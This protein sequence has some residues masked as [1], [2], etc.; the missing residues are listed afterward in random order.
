MIDTSTL[1]DPINNR[2]KGVYAGEGYSQWDAIVRTPKGKLERKGRFE[3]PEAAAYAVAEYYHSVYG[4]NWPKIMRDW[5]RRKSW[6]VRRVKRYPYRADL[7]RG[8]S[9]AIWIADVKVCPISDTWYRITLK[10][11]LDMTN[12]TVPNNVVDMWDDANEGWKNSTV[13]VIV[14]RIFRAH[15]PTRIPSCPP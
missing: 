8:P 6:R 13:A 11:I 3:T 9:I 1:Y 7:H 14:V 12:N 4:P 10:D 2:Y 15:N 5:D